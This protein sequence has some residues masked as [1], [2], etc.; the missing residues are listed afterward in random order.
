[1]IRPL[2]G[3]ALKGKLSQRHLF[4]FEVIDI[5]RNF[6]KSWPKKS[7]SG[8]RQQISGI[9]LWI[10]VA[11]YRL[12]LSAKETGPRDVARGPRQGGERFSPDHIMGIFAG[13]D[14]A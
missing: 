14:R 7:G 11:D 1:M 8:E 10:K 5:N 4:V 6:L 3:S 9:I 12:I 2:R 13:K